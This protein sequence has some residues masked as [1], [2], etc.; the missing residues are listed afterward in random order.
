MSGD[1]TLSE[2]IWNKLDLHQ[3]NQD[4]FGLPDRITAKRFIFKLLYGATAYGFYTD[5]DFIDV[6]FSEKEWQEVIDR[7]YTKYRGIAEWHKYI[8]SY[9]Q[10]HRRLVI[11]SGRYFPYEPIIRRGELK[12]PITTIKNYPIN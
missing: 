6:G 12:W 10:Q 8:I 4:K 9:V 5:S 3:D 11:P 1:K 7:F 2:E